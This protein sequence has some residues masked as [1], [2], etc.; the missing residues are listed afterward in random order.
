M[1][2][3][4]NILLPT[5]TFMEMMQYHLYNVQYT[6]PLHSGRAKGLKND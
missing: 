2:V 1:F 5:R 4:Q 6:L 3:T